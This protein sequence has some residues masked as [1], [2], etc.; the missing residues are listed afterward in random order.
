MSK[1]Y[2]FSAAAASLAYIRDNATTIFVCSSAPQSY[3]AASNQPNMIV[4]A[5]ASAADFVITSAATGALLTIAAKTGH[6][7]DG[8]GTATH[9]AVVSVSG[10]RLLYVTNASSQVLSSGNTVTI[11]SWTITNLAS[12]NN[13]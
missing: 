7:I 2:G 3:S 13:A 10:S 12:A 8:S 11:N 1:K 6:T 4:S 5:G 9:L